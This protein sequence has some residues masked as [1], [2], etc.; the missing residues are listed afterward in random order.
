MPSPVLPSVCTRPFVLYNFCA[1]NLF[2]G[3]TNSSTGGQFS[4]SF[5][6]QY[7][8]LNPGPYIHLKQVLYHYAISPGLSCPGLQYSSVVSI[9]LEWSMPGLDF[10]PG[11]KHPSNEESHPMVSF[12]VGM[13]VRR[14]ERS[15]CLSLCLSHLVILVLAGFFVCFFLRQRTVWQRMAL[16]SFLILLLPPHKWDH[17]CA[18]H[19]WLSSVISISF[20]F[21]P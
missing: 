16:N 17:M 18:P 5:F 10:S 13:V 11:E 12:E 8:E 19:G 20:P 9:Y 21:K 1:W 6:V 15:I 2:Q 7:W 4:S 3:K 14:E